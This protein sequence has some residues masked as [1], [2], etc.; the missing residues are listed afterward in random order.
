MLHVVTA[1]CVF[2]AYVGESEKTLRGLFEKAS[3]TAQE[4]KTVVLFFDEVLQFSLM[5][6]PTVFAQIDAL[7]PKR[8]AERPHESRVVSQML[9]LMDG[10]GRGD[11]QNG[12]VVIVAATNRPN[13]LDAALRRPGRFDREVEV[14]IPDQTQRFEIL[15][16]VLHTVRQRAQFVSADYMPPVCNSMQM[17]ISR[18]SLPG[19]MD[20][21]ELISVRFVERL[22]CMPSPKSVRS[23]PVSLS[24]NFLM[25]CGS[26]GSAPCVIVED[27]EA[28]LLVVPPSVCRSYEIESKE[29]QWDD[30]GG[31]QDV[32]KQLRQAAEWPL[33]HRSAFDRLGLKPAKGILLY[34]PPGCCKTTLALAVA[35]RCKAHL[36][37]LSCAQVLK[38]H[39][40]RNAKCGMA[41]VFDVC[42]RGRGHCQ[43][44][45]P[46]CQD[47]ISLYCTA[48]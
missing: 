18:T 5:H 17:S 11:E 8:S 24:S 28:A 19:L 10:A 26:S 35:T 1:A 29:V 16:H 22:R 12:H 46:S 4:G 2:G 45:V 7:C 23:L 43:R 41:G 37:P 38:L 39:P 47:C 42:R 3:E 36:L 6:P 34:G 48:G 44:D 14:N 15:K 30:I 27:F 32:K 40:L 9:T 33:V 21:V 13:A 20:T 31:L 25:V